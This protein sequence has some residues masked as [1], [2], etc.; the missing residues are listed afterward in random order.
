MSS[1]YA[2]NRAINK[3]LEFKGLRAQ[4]I[5][6]LAAG[7]LALLIGF[8]LMYVLGL[9]TYLCLFLVFGAGGAW[10]SYIFRLSH[11][12]GAHGLMKRNAARQVPLYL[13]FHSRKLFIQLKRKD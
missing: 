10:I 8:A 5:G 11:R 7:L 2:I 13:K 1:V 12:Y 6:Y 3:S 9:N 4:Y